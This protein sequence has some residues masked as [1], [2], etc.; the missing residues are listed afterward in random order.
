MGRR[1]FEKGAVTGTENAY[2][3]IY[4]NIFVKDKNK[5][6]KCKKKNSSLLILQR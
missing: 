5:N 6:K 4:R 3:S 2:R 1:N